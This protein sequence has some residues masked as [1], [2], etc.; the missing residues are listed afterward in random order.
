MDTV[1]PT[2]ANLPD[3]KVA[4]EDLNAA[5]RSF[6][7]IELLAQLT[8]TFLFVP[9]DEFQSDDSDVIKWSRYIE[10]VAGQTQ[11]QEP[12][13]FTDKRPTGQDLMKVE[14]LLEK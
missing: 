8:L 14:E 9:K 3:P 13:R 7:P 5:L 12:A 10:F 4:Y 1:A 6:D 11:C 2:L